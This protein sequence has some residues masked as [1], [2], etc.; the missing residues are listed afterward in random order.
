MKIA[1]TLAYF[2]QQADDALARLAVQVARRLVRQY[3]FGFVKYGPG[4][5][6]AL[7][8]ASAQFV[9][10]AVQLVR[11]P[12]LVEHTGDALPAFGLPLMSGGPKDEV[13]ILGDGAVG[14]Q[15]EV[16]KDDAGL[17]PQLRYAPLLHLGEVVAQDF[18]CASAQRQLGVEGF[19]YGTF[20]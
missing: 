16:L 18:A 4:N 13:E 11:Q 6:H 20:A 14:Q 8:L 9:G 1:L 12:Y 15:L 7:L 19:E 3:D 2:A 10:K 17:A 5:G